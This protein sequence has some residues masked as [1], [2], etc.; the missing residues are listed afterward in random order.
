MLTL[1][2]ETVLTLV[3][4]TVLTLVEATV[5]TLAFD[6][7]ADCFSSFAVSD[8][9]SCDSD[10]D[11][12]S[13]SSFSS[14][15]ASSSSPVKEAAKPSIT[16]QVAAR[17]TKLVSTAVISPSALTKL[18][19]VLEIVL[20][21]RPRMPLFLFWRI[22]SLLIQLEV[23]LP[24]RSKLNVFK[25]ALRLSIELMSLGLV[26]KSAALSVIP[27]AWLNNKVSPS[28]MATPPAIAAALLGLIVVVGS[29]I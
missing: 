20:S 4:D 14:S 6:A 27:R 19:M 21:R 15:S 23:P 17:S 1:V 25:S 28:P 13:S 16:V 10:R 22:D 7:E 9:L 24:P 11:S 5:L 18:Q 26:A 12:F 3:E 8:A 29:A 2:E